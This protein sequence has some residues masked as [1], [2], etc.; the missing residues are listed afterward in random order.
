MS[1]TF[2]R[3]DLM[4]Q[5][6]D[7]QIFDGKTYADLLGTS[8]PAI[9][10]NATDIDAGTQFA[11]DQ[12]Q[13]DLLCSDLTSVPLARAVAAS[14][15]VPLALSPIT[16]VNYPSRQCGYE[17]P[18]WASAEVASGAISSRRYEEARRIRH[19][20]EPEEMR[21]VHLIDGGIVDN[22][23]LRSLYDK[24]TAAGGAVPLV[25]RTGYTRFRRIL[26]VVVNAQQELSGEGAK[27][28]GVPGPIETVMGATKLTLDRYSFETVENFRREIG[29]WIEEIKNARCVPGA[30]RT[31]RGACDDLQAYF[32]EL[33]FAQH[34]D[35]EEREFLVNLPT[36]LKLDP[37]TV[38]RVVAAAR[39][40]L[41]ESTAFGEFLRDLAAL[42]S[43]D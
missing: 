2:G 37:A 25:E 42:E 39:V 4:A 3:S 33:N 24:A 17:L 12:D 26:H 16:R 8:A 9:I 34:P 22:L 11:F 43:T 13:F 27:E 5:Y 29:G 38:D 19:Y 10:I 23:G 6:F 14:S 7:E 35:P 15:A 32:V 31:S 30:V 41:D 36:S 28:E 20:A 1:P 18:D 40:I 21:Y